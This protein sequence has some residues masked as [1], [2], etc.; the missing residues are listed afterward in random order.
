MTPCLGPITFRCDDVSINTN[1]SKLWDM[2]RLLEPYRVILGISPLVFE[3][4]MRDTGKERVYPE[5]LN[6]HSDHRL[7]YKADAC[8]LPEAIG[9]NFALAGHGLVHVDHRLLSREAQELSIITS[10]SLVGASIFI[11]PFNKWN[12]DTESICQEQG[13]GLI[14]FEDGWQHLKHHPIGKPDGLYYFHTH[15]FNTVSEFEQCLRGLQLENFGVPQSADS[16]TVNQPRDGV[17]SK[18]PGGEIRVG[19][20][21]DP[22]SPVHPS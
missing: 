15:D 16:G 7:L 17:Q 2:L 5:I 12:R 22:A 13:Y 6:A 1:H 4:M 10:C 14:K 3:T 8:G 20:E 11:P 9:W 18:E 21:S 19:D